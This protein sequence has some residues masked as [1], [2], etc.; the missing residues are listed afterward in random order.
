M[1]GGRSTEPIAIGDR[2]MPGNR[3]D[4]HHWI[5]EVWV[6]PARRRCD[7]SCGQ[8][9]SVLCV[10]YLMGGQFERIDPN[11]ADWLLVVASSFA[12]HPEPSRGNANQDGFDE[13]GLLAAPS[14]Q[15]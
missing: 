11:A 15:T 4:W 5:A 9:A 7:A 3:N 13:V 2:F 10:R 12:S 8:K 1:F 6:G 14:I